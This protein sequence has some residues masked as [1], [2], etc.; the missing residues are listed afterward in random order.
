MTVTLPAAPR[1]RRAPKNHFVLARRRSARLGRLFIVLVVL[2]GVALAALTSP[3]M[4]AIP[5]VLALLAWAALTLPL[6]LVAPGIVGLLLSLSSPEV[7]P[8]ENKWR[9]P[10]YPLGK[11]VYKNL[12]VKFAV[13]DILIVLLLVRAVMVIVLSEQGRTGIDRRPPRP[14]AQATLIA[15]VVVIAW[16]VYGIGTGGGIKNSLWQVRP[17]IMLPALALAVAVAATPLGIQRLRTAILFAGLVKAFEGITFYYGVVKPR[18]L[19]VAYVTT[20]SDTVLWATATCILLAE[21]FEMRNR[22]SRR[23]L[24]VLLPLYAIAMVLNNRRTVWVAVLA[25]LAFI[26]VVAHRPVKRQLAKLL[27]IGWPLVVTYIVVGFGTHSHS[28]AFKP[29]SMIDSVLFQRDVSSSTRDIENFN[30]LVTLRARPLIGWGFGHPYI[31]SVRAYDISKFFAQ[32]RYLPHNSF[33]GLWAFCG[34]IFAA[35]YFLLPVVAIFYAVSSLRQSRS[36][37][38][39]SSAAWAVCA[40][41]AY[42]VQGW[43]DIGLQDWTA[44]VCAGV[45]FGIGGALPRLVA[46]ERSRNTPA[47]PIPAHH[48]DLQP[49]RE[50][51]PVR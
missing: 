32:Y 36:P 26:V 2:A 16:L 28:I 39:R 29:V 9:S 24:L 25:G 43:A 50:F 3:A 11:I 5:A 47:E 20:H 49:R 13:V 40:V 45:G 1:T 8:A 12:P 6:D 33:L 44:I 17:L 10:L 42:L 23:N 18:G 19:N 22:R 14:F 34:P 46:R 4:A 41:I 30:L 35:G 7:N 48:H 31:E 38:V 37:L 15:G 27:G 51:T 21:W